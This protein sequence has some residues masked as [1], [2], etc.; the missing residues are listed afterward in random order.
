MKR[1]YLD[2]DGVIVVPENE[3]RPHEGCIYALNLIL[4]AIPET[5]IVISSNW[6]YSHRLCQLRDIVASWGVRGQVVDVT[7]SDRE[8]TTGLIVAYPREVEIRRHVER[9]KPSAWVAIDDCIQGGERMIQTN[10]RKGLTNRLA[11]MA[12]KWLNTPCKGD[13]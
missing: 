13:E 11:E 4:A 9:T 8:P 10:P 3:G 1:L 5:E 6:Q 2:F 12:I 7:D